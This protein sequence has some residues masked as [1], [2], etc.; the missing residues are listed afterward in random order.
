MLI[1]IKFRARH[2]AAMSSDASVSWEGNVVETVRDPVS[3]QRFGNDPNAEDGSLRLIEQLHM[4]LGILLELAGNACRHVGTGAGQGLPGSIAVGA[5]GPE[6]RCAG[7]ATV[8]DAEKIERHVF[9][10]RLLAAPDR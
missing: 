6:F 8:S 10:S 2:G 9:D 5:F 3:I 4:P 1:S 7:V